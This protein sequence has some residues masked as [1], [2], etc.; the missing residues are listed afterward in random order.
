VRAGALAKS[1]KGTTSISDRFFIGVLFPHGYCRA[2]LFLPVKR[3]DKT[4][5]VEFFYKAQLDKVA[6]VS[7]FLALSPMESMNALMPS[8]EGNW[9][10]GNLSSVIDTS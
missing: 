9:L 6:G 4:A 1:K 10:R 5:V 8:R 7:V 2:N 3:V